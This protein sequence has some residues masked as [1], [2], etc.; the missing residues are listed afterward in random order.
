[1][2]IFPAYITDNLFLDF[3][4]VKLYELKSLSKSAFEPNNRQILIKN[5]DN[6]LN[7]FDFLYISI[8]YP[9]TLN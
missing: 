4:L 6:S 9:S 8:Q 7:Y 2:H 3:V 1:M 5:N